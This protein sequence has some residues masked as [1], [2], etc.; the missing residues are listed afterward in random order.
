MLYGERKSRDNAMLVTETIKATLQDIIHKHV[1]Y[2]STIC[3]DDNHSYKGVAHWNKTVNYSAR[4]SLNGIK[5]LWVTFKQRFYG[6]YH[7]WSAKYCCQFNNDFALCLNESNVEVDTKT[8][9]TFC[10][11]E[12]SASKPLPYQALTRQ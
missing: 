7:Y 10:S 11:A 8:D 12:Y 2:G 3:T 5:S 1:H 6:T 4:K 9:W